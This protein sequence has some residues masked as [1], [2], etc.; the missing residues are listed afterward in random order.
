MAEPNAL[1][2]EEYRNVK[3]FDE[4]MEAWQNGKSK[5]DCPYDEDTRKHEEWIDGYEVM[6]LSDD[7]SEL[8]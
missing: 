7:S 4:G 5:S 6:V 2:D 1:T 8:P 3:A